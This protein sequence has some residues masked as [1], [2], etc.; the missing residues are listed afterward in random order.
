MR[1]FHCFIHIV[2]S[3]SHVRANNDNGTNEKNG[4]KFCFAFFL[5]VGVVPRFSSKLFVQPIIGFCRLSYPSKYKETASNQKHQS[6][7]IHYTQKTHNIQ[8]KS[9]LSTRSKWRQLRCEYVI[10][11]FAMIHRHR[12]KREKKECGE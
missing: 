9:R 11:L 5:I 6:N 7:E 4:N 1:V 2:P 10:Y 3:S 8:K 12:K